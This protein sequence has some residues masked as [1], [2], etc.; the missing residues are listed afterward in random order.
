MSAFDLQTS[1]P[2]VHTPDYLLSS[3]SCRQD[4]IPLKSPQ[5]QAGIVAPVYTPEVVAVRK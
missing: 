3:D 4:L 5:G 2:S 1:Q